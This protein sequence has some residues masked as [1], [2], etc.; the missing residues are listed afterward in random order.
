MNA[1]AFGGNYAFTGAPGNFRSGIMDKGYTAECGGCKVGQACDHGEAKGNVTASLIAGK[2]LGRDMGDHAS[3]MGPRQDAFSH[4]RYSTEWIKEAFDPQ[5]PEFQDS[6]M[7]IMV[8]FAVENE[9]MCEQLY[10]ANKGNGG[11]GSDGYPC[12]KGDSFASLERQINAIKAWVGE[13]RDWMEIAYTS[14]DARRIVN[15]D[16]L[17]VILGVESEYSFGAEDRAFDPVERPRPL[18]RHGRAH[19]LS[20]AQDQQPSRRRRHLLSRRD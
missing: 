19:L 9:A 13:N 8:A 10:Y 16:K 4:A 11:P 7:R 6:R 14:A 2:P 18:L 12:S 5:E 17:A 3:H 20:G 15:A 1:M